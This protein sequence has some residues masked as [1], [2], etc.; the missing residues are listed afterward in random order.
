[1]RLA[2]MSYSYARL[3]ATGEATIP[4][5]I[6]SIRELGVDAVE[7][8]DAAVHEKDLAAIQA[9]LAENGSQVACYDVYADFAAADP[10][11]RR[12]TVAT[13]RQG[14]DR[15]ELFRARQIMLVPLAPP[16]D[17]PPDVARSRI[18][19][20]IT[21]CLPEATRRGLTVSIENLGVLA[22]V[23]GTSDHLNAIADASGPDLGITFDAGNFLLA[24]EDPL[25]ALER[26]LTRVRHVHLK[27]WQVVSPRA[28]PVAGEYPGL[29]GR[30]YRAAALGEGVVDLRSV[31][32][33][34]RA[35]GYAGYVSVEYEGTEDPRAA[36]RRGVGYA[37]VLLGGE[38][39]AHPGC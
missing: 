5:V 36:V 12:A 13:V 17:L 16:R 8:S 4:T 38:A 9:A 35:H 25:H 28:M 29:D 27:D 24:G 14:F 3:L 26:V 34:L 22:L 39:S 1:M 23:C 15:A 33:E 18:A 37:R 31:V 20:G 32:A 30:W 21:E 11:R 6:R 2:V 7:L 19:E 10:A